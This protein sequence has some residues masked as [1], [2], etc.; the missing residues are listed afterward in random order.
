METLRLFIAVDTP[1]AVKREMALLRDELAPRSRDVRWEA[2]GK[3]HCTLRFLGNVERSRLTSIGQ[4]VESAASETPPLLL[5]YAGIGVFPDRMRP[6]VIWIGVRESGGDLARLQERISGGLRALGFVLEERPF[7]PHVTLARARGVGGAGSAARVLIDIAET[8]TF[9]HP[10][11]IVPAVEI[12]QSVL[13]PRGSEYVV[14]R[15]IPLTGAGGI[16]PGS[17]GRS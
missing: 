16:S 7:H 17:P 8:R 15:S 10:P 14:L 5:T 1:A 2:A 3:L 11:V 13:R 6:R 4:Q 9:E 12:M